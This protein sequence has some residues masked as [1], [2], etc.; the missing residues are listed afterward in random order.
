LQIW[1]KCKRCICIS[2]GI[3][4]LFVINGCVTLKLFFEHSNVY[5]LVTTIWQILTRWNIW[6]FLYIITLNY[7]VIYIP[8]N[9]IQ[10]P[11]SFRIGIPLLMAIRVI[12]GCA[13]AFKYYTF[14]V[15]T[16]LTWMDKK[17]VFFVGTLRTHTFFSNCNGS[18]M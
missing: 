16:H 15:K 6:P 13:T 7:Q 18:Q 12:A 3:N 1:K 5:H 17:L 9:K 4:K 14:V 10:H 8:W 11:M 2:Y